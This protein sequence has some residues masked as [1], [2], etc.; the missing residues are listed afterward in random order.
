MQTKQNIYEGLLVLYRRRQWQPTP[1]LLPG[2]SHG[3][4]S[5]VG[6][7]P[8]GREESDTTEW[9]H[10]HFTLVYMVSLWI[11]LELFMILPLWSWYS[12]AGWMVAGTDGNSHFWFRFI[13]LLHSKIKQNN[14]L[15]F[16]SILQLQG[17]FIYIVWLFKFQL[18]LPPS[19]CMYVSLSLQF[20][21][22]SEEVK[23][24]KWTRK[25]WVL[26]SACFSILISIPVGP[27]DLIICNSMCEKAGF[28]HSGLSTF[29]LFFFF[30][31]TFISWRLI[32]Y[33]IVV[34]FAIHWHESAIDLH[35]FTIPILPPTSLPI[36]LGLPS[37]PA[38][39]TCLMHPFWAGVIYFKLMR[40]Y[41]IHKLCTVYRKCIYRKW[42]F[43]F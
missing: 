32:T 36:P 28:K 29:F 33:S 42:G 23:C 1:V 41:N 6:C 11:D 30:S 16:C 37:A 27:T 22:G 25:W 5:L 9:L 39:S 10:F 4:R 18:M 2:T 21:S 17:V 8:W 13:F 40:Q 12:S 26:G 38:L 7:S 20:Q 34:V 24:R 31:F 43:S 35:V 3:Q 19:N 14:V 15:C